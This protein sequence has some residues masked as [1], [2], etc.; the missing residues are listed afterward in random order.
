MPA[1]PYSHSP[2]FDEQTLPAAIR[3]AHSTKDGVWGLLHVL[4]GEVDLLFPDNG[5]RE[6]VTPGHPALIP[7]QEK[8][9]VELRG[10]MRMQIEFYRENP[11][12]GAAGASPHG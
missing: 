4:D 1:V 5:R 7:P 3:T 2:I 11:L 6:H 9:H 10:A 8:H 12:D